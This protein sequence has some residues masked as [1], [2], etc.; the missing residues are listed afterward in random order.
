MAIE[1]I[2]EEVKK[3]NHQEREK[4][5]DLMEEADLLPEAGS[6]QRSTA[7][8]KKLVG[9]ISDPE[10]GSHTYEKELYGG[11]KPL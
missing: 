5:M 10:G 7:A 4:L 2:L 9:L 8:L 11:P 6:P 3:L 1:R